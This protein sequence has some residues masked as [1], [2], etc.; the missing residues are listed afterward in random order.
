M[1]NRVAVVMSTYNGQA[2]LREQ[3]DSLLRQTLPVDVYVRDDGSND[4]T[5]AILDEYAH[6]HECI[7]VY[8]DINLGCTKSFLMAL[9]LAP[10]FYDYYAFCD[11]DD[12]WLE[13]KIERAVEA[14]DARG[15]V[16]SF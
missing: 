8:K 7:H 5:V 13:D 3:L 11:Q 6:A 9:D 10:A 1:K 16:I 14:L 4:A 2:Y 15:G 12:I